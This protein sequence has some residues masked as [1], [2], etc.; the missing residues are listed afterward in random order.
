MRVGLA[1]TK[2]GAVG[3]G[4]SAA[5]L[6]EAVRDTLASYL[7]GP[8]VELVRLEALSTRQAE[9]EARAA[10]CDL[11]LYTSASYRKGGGGGFGGFLKKAAPIADSVIPYGD[12][13]AGHAASRVASEAVYTAADAAEN[14][15]A[16]D[17]LTLELT[18]QGLADGAAPLTKTVR[19]KA[20]SDGDDLVS[21]LA[22]QAAAEVLGAAAKAGR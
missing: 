11:V 20:K 10:G 2:T 19:A 18:L 16:K 7:N 14:V 22:A 15:K 13:A 17:E 1:M 5:K 4:M 9:A 12:D 3:E 21:R 6:A 8:T